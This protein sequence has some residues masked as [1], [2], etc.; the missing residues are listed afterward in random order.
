[1]ENV[2]KRLEKRWRY[3]GK[4][5]KRLEKVQRGWENVGKR[6]EKR[7]R[8]VGKDWKGLKRLEK[9][10]KGLK[11][12]EKVGKSLKRLEKGWRKCGQKKANLVEESEQ[13]E[14]TCDGAI[15]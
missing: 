9:V 12:F 13:N 10:G 15:V 6:L 11:K 14:K 1:M 4:G 5:W 3:F 8:N 2:R 7:W